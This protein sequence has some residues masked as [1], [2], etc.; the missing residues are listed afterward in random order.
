MK[1]SPQRVLCATDFSPNARRAAEVAGAI[2]KRLR[3]TLVLVHVADEPHALGEN[4]RDFRRAMRRA[5]SRLAAEAKRL[6][7]DGIALEQVLLHGRWAE[8]EI[9]EY[10]AKCP[11]R[12]V[13]VSSVSKTAFDRWTLGSVSEHVV[14][15]SPVATLVVRSPDRLLEWARQ[16]RTLRIVVAVDLTPSAD[17]ALALVEDLR[18]IGDC[19]VTAAHITWPPGEPGSL[20]RTEPSRTTVSP[21]VRKRRSREVRRQVARVYRGAFEVKIEPHPARPDAAL[22]FLAA[23]A[24]ADLIVVGAHQRHGWQRLT[25]FSISRGVMRHAAMNVACAPVSMAMAHDQRRP[26][27]R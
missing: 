17:A 11:P 9:G 13:V 19:T 21:L 16:E 27:A 2:A 7:P 18:K 3:T 12:L 24:D 22:V 23:E 20:R 8:E 1:T 25:R 6:D 15:H 4:T 5:K 14:Q 26:D 10:V